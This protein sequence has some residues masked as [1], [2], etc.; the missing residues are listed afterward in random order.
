MF[1]PSVAFCFFSG[2]QP[3]KVELYVKPQDLNAEQLQI[4]VDSM[5]Q[6]DGLNALVQNLRRSHNVLENA[7][8][9]SGLEITMECPNLD[10]LEK[11]L[12][13][14]ET[15]RLNEVAERNLVTEEIKMVLCLETVR[16]ET[17][18]KEHSYL[19]IL[20]KF[21]ISFVKRILT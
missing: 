17:V 11:L 15:G 9:K 1:F 5:Q 4:F 8:T 7:L 2:F 14:H 16:L 12:N 18:F 21:H 6:M 19:E 10:S 13:D 3:I 20:S